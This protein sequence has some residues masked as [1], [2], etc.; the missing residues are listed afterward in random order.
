MKIQ[1]L[2]KRLREKAISN[3]GEISNEVAAE[4]ADAIAARFFRTWAPGHS[5]VIAVFWPIKSEINI[6]LLIEKLHRAGLDIVLPEVV[7]SSKLLLFRKWT[8]EAKMTKGS[9]KT[10]V[11]TANAAVMEP[12]WILVPLL[13]FDS[14]R[15]RLGY[16]GGYYDATLSHLAKKKEIFTIGVAYDVQEFDS[17]PKESS[18]FQLDAVLTEKRVIKKEGKYRCV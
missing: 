13:A 2:K 4:A 3:R 12:D 5:T 8:P 1:E 10:S 6:R 9:Y 16:G 11:L 15:F 18:D 14:E 7:A 17:V